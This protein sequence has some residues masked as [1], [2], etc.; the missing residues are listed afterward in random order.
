[1]TCTVVPFDQFKKYAEREWNLTMWTVLQAA[2]DFSVL[3]GLQVVEE[4]LV[5]PDGPSFALLLLGLLPA[6]L[7]I[8][9][10]VDSVFM[11][12][13]LEKFSLALGVI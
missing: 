11:L 3:E 9:I 6:S 10:L 8:A 7:S 2:T 12:K 5:S 1:M 4:L 13:K